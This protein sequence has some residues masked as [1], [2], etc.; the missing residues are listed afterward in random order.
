ME[1]IIIPYVSSVDTEE[2]RSAKPHKIVDKGKYIEIYTQA[3]VT[4][5]VED[6]LMGV[7]SLKNLT[8]DIK[9]CI[10]KD[11]ILYVDYYY[12]NFTNQYRVTMHYDNESYQCFPVNSKEDAEKY[13]DKLMEIITN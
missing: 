2:V 8:Y 7:A 12:S 4:S 1:T 13:L 5:N 3:K 10:I 9:S 11:K 6:D